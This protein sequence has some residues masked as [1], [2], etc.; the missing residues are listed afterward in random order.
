MFYNIVNGFMDLGRAGATVARTAVPVI[1]VMRRADDG[2]VVVGSQSCSIR[3]T[4]ATGHGGG[5]R[6][7]DGMGQERSSE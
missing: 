3:T 7:L 5:W 2:A 1:A 4:I 6:R